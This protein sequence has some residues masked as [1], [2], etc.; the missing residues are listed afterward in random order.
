LKLKKKNLKKH[1]THEDLLHFCPYPATYR[2][3]G[4][5]VEKYG[6]SKEVLTHDYVY[7]VKYEQLNVLTAPAYKLS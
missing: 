6:L 1:K 5:V 7:P 2:M 3:F 4:A